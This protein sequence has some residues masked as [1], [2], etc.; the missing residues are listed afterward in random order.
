MYVP[1]SSPGN[2]PNIDHMLRKFD[3]SDINLTEE[4]TLKGFLQ[5]NPKKG[6]GPDA[7]PTEFL[8]NYAESL[9]KPLHFSFNRSLATGIFPYKWKMLILTPIFKSGSRSDL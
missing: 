3:I 8:I 6:A 7:I 9:V 4:E 5:L 2:T 1:D